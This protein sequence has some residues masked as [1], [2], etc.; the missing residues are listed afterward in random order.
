MAMC[1]W[2]FGTAR[3]HVCN[4]TGAQGDGR[5]R[6]I[7]GGNGNRTHCSGAVMRRATAVRAGRGYVPAEV[8]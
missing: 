8:H 3:C 7:C 1:S 6:A 5:V 4:G 2:R